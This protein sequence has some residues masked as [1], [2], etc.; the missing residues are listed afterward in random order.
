MHRVA[1]RLQTG[2]DELA[3]FVDR[4]DPENELVGAVGEVLRGEE[5]LADDDGQRLAEELA[6]HFALDGE[7][8]L[9]LGG[10][11]VVDG[12]AEDEDVPGVRAATWRW[13]SCPV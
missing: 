13:S 8:V 2:R 11:Q 7:L 3:H 5:V 1:E 6:V 10:E 12:A 9:D 4:E